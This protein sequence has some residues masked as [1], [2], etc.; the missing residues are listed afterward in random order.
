MRLIYSSHSTSDFFVFRRW[1]I[2]C[3][4]FTLSEAVFLQDL[5]NHGASQERKGRLDKEGYF[6]CKGEYLEKRLHCWTRHVQTKLFASL[7][8]KKILRIRKRGLPPKRYVLIQMSALASMEFAANAANSNA[9]NEAR[10]LPQTRPYR[11]L[12]NNSKK[13]QCMSRVCDD[14]TD[15][16][17]FEDIESPKKTN[18]PSGF[19]YTISDELWQFV[20]S[21]G[22]KHPKSKYSK[23]A[24]E[25]RLLRKSAK[26]K[27]IRKAVDWYIA[28][29]HKLDPQYRPEIMSASALREKYLKLVGAMKRHIA[30]QKN[31]DGFDPEEEE[32]NS[33]SWEERL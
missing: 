23:W 3:G 7:I 25:I 15:I 24:N 22:Y 28:N 26:K 29:F 21:I 18:S 4:K 11:A 20:A 1:L 8:H 9:A 31:E 33:N 2:N 13:E 6:L 10:N 5:I 27:D 19:D 17:I 30:K 32:R 12:G 14:A 16:P